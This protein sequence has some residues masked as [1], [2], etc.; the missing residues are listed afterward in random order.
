M[1]SLCL[2]QLSAMD[3]GIQTAH[4]IVEYG[5]MFRNDDDYQ[6]WAL[7]DKTLILLN[8]GTE[9]D[10]N[11]FVDELVEHKVKF[12]TFT[13]PDLNGLI[14]SIVFLADERVWD[15]KSY[16][17][18]EDWSNDLLD[19]RISNLGDKPFPYTRYVD[20]DLSESLDA[21]Y[22]KMIGG[23]ANLYLKMTLPTLKLAQ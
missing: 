3:K 2:R 22:K 19:W 20:K 17:K 8:G 12:A 7:T 4:A 18:F 16:P 10:L 13:E 15:F 1:Y 5:N 21:S 6:Q 11:T 23:D 14:T 9:P